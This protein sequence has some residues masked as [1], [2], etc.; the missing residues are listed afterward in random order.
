MH[1]GLVAS[2]E[3]PQRIRKQ[4][5]RRD[6]RSRRPTH[7]QAQRREQP[8]IRMQSNQVGALRMIGRFKISPEG[9]RRNKLG[10]QVRLIA[11]PENRIPLGVAFGTPTDDTLGKIR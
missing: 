11:K 5:R 7:L 3:W 6:I 10:A 2:Q 4:F 9:V 8:A 1:D